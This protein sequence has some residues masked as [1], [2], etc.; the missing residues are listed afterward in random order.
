[1]IIYLIL[2]FLLHILSCNNLFNI[3]FSYYII[4]LILKWCN[5]QEN[6]ISPTMNKVFL[7]AHK[8]F[9]TSVH[10]IVFTVVLLF[11]PTLLTVMFLSSSERF[12]VTRF[13]PAASLCAATS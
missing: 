12:S 13:L 5:F 1:M 7:I 11:T 3:S 6:P 2:S 9:C 4:Y 10:L 8:C